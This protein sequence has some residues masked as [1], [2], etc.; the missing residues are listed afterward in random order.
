MT[1]DKVILITY[2]HDRQSSTSPLNTDKYIG[3][4]MIDKDT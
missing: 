2:K 1:E 4:S 3:K